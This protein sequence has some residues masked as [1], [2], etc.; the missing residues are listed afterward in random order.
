V[1]C[2]D[3]E[4]EDVGVASVDD[5]SAAAQT[6][7]ATSLLTAATS[8]RLDV[9]RDNS[10]S[11]I[12]TESKS[13]TEVRRRPGIRTAVSPPSQ[14]SPKRRKLQ[15]PSGSAG[16]D[17]TSEENNESASCAQTSS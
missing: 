11:D 8:Q 6:D 17:D 15:R 16:D 10:S 1:R 13:V 4:D 9:G 5:E 7:T 3:A 2:T 12:D 14:V